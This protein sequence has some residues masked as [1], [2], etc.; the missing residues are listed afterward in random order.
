MIEDIGGIPIVE[1]KLLIEK[2]QVSDGSVE[3]RTHTD[4][5]EEHI[6]ITLVREQVDVNRVP[7]NV[8]VD[9]APEIRVD[10][11]LTI[12]PVLE[13]RL[14]VEKRLVLVEEIHIRK[15]AS[16]ETERVEAVLRKQ[17]VTVKRTE[18]R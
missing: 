18:M 16:S 9:V 3:V 8:V 12:I 6:E 7:F 14:V 15:T 1:E 17:R 4:K 10:G 11:D 2:K 13:E 5:V